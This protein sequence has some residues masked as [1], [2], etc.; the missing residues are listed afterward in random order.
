MNEY[1]ELLIFTNK[2]NTLIFDITVSLR[3]MLNYLKF[4]CKSWV[5]LLNDATR[6]V[7][8][9]VV[10]QLR[11]LVQENHTQGAVRG[12]PGNWSFYLDCN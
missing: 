8:I 9:N 6:T 4:S 3:I 2:G 5:T 11:S 7:I 12:R 10:N 1:I